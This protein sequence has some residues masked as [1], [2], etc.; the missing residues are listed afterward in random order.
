MRRPPFTVALEK[1]GQRKGGERTRSNQGYTCNTVSH[2][3]QSFGANYKTNV[4]T[5]N[6]ATSKY[7][8]CYAE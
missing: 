1:N 5:S 7:E 8:P 3:R 6:Y 2:E 4:V